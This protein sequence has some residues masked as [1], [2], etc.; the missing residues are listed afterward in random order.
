MF[1]DCNILQMRHGHFISILLYEKIVSLLFYLEDLISRHVMC[2]KLMKGSHNL[3]INIKVTKNVEGPNQLI[4]AN[5]LF[6]KFT[7]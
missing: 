2:A 6:R 5:K 3:S 4:I 1:Y 7:K